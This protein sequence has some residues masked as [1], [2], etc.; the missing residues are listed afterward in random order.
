MSK[1]ART[2]Q[3]YITP[4]PASLEDYNQIAM[5]ESRYGLEVKSFEEWSHL[6]LDNPAYRGLED[7]WPIG[8]VIEDDSKRIVGSVGNIPLM[9][10][11]GGRRV[12][13]ASA[14]SWVV[15]PA[16]RS[17][18]LLLLDYVINQP[19]VELYLNNTVGAR[20]L[21]AVDA[22][23]CSR[24]PVGVWDK[25]AFWITNHRGFFESLIP[26]KHC[27]L[28]KALSYPLSALTRVIEWL[29]LKPI[30]K[31]DVEVQPCSDFD[32]RFDAFWSELRKNNPH[33][34]LALRT[35]EVLA[36]HFKY[37][38]RRNRLWIATIPDGRR[39]VAYAIFELTINPR[40]G[41]KRLRLVDF[42]SL[43]EG[44]AFITPLLAWA[45]KKCRRAG[46]HILE[47]TGRWL[48]RSSTSNRRA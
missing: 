30:S 9:Y 10:E 37:A 24:V 20:S 39:L 17:L 25:S 38:L 4:R 15:E 27:R 23:Q 18:S 31:R 22:Y 6:W 14:R 11:F 29:T 45:L 42:Q 3:R 1:H 47:S 8:W 7:S 26:C 12:L 5:L 21:A 34:L 41:L 19:G 46:I 43:D 35:R 33:V 44:R 16:W 40:S 28:A 32:D 48:A 13:A 2:A 36:W